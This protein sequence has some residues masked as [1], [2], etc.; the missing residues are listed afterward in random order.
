M[1]LIGTVMCLTVCMVSLSE[2]VVDRVVLHTLLVFH[3]LTCHGVSLH[4]AVG[5]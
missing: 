5:E 3:L 2:A 4:G 1:G